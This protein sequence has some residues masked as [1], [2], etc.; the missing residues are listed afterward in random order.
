M[1]IF[2]R[3]NTTGGIRNI[4]PLMLKTKLKCPSSR[5]I[6]RED[7]G[8]GRTNLKRYIPSERF[9]YEPKFESH[10]S[11]FNKVKIKSKEKYRTQLSGGPN[12][13][14]YNYIYV[15]LSKKKIEMSSKKCLKFVVMIQ[16]KWKS[17]YQ[18]KIFIRIRDKNR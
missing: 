15:D 18:R 7:H 8:S 6:K 4:S 3:L 17:I 10:I 14:V 11:D 12:V 5:V 13:K 16:A 2:N 1:A 9:F